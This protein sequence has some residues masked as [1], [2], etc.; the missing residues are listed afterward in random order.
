MDTPYNLKGDSFH[1]ML[2]GDIYP[3]RNWADHSLD[4]AQSFPVRVFDCSSNFMHVLSFLMYNKRTLLG[5]RR[6]RHSGKRTHG[7]WAAQGVRFSH[8]HISN[9]QRVQD[10]KSGRVIKVTGNV[11]EYVLLRDQS[12]NACWASDL[13]DSIIMRK[14]LGNGQVYKNIYWNLKVLGEVKGNCSVTGGVKAL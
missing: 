11:V 4:G 7:L 2:L 6:H 14:S 5:R 13:R 3:V 8:V 9:F 1:I 10:D 12:T